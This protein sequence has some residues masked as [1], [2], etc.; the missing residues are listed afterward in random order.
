[1]PPAKVNVSP[2][3]IVCVPESPAIVKVVEPPGEEFVIVIAPAPLVI[4]IPVPPVSVD[5][6]KVFPVE[7]PISNCPSV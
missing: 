5:F 7:F 2:S 1:M 6:D 3:A 4:V